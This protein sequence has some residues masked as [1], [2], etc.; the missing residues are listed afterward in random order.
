MITLVF[1]Q[2]SPLLS[3]SNDIRLE[4]L[5]CLETSDITVIVTEIFCV[6]LS[7]VSRDVSVMDCKKHKRK[8]NNVRFRKIPDAGGENVSEVLKQRFR[9]TK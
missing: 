7:G 9:V 3:A 4:V 1:L 5:V 6:Q 2:H 8:S